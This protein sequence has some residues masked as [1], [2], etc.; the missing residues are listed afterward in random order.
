MTWILRQG[1]PGLRGGGGE[2]GCTNVT[3]TIVWLPSQLDLQI[4]D[5]HEHGEHQPPPSH[6]L[7]PELKLLPTL[8]L[9]LHLESK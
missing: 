8:V 9:S 5:N 7:R 6:K 4:S 3:S 2:G 1:S